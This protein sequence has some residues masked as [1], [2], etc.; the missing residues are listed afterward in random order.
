MSQ[1]IFKTKSLSKKQCNKFSLQC[2][3]DFPHLTRRWQFGGCLN[4]RQS[5][6][7]LCDLGNNNMTKKAV[8][9]LLQVGNFNTSVYG[10]RFASGGSLKRPFEKLHLCIV[11]FPCLEV[12]VAQRLAAKFCQL[13]G[14]HVVFIH[15][16]W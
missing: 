7:F 13:A 4:K 10:D 3:Q 16:H 14:N 6:I 12:A 9:L 8:F 15:L 1:S 11:I 2:G 5:S